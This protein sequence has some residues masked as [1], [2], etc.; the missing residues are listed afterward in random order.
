MLL[1]FNFS[2]SLE[3]CT[4]S[5]G[6]CFGRIHFRSNKHH[7]AQGIHIGNCQA[8]YHIPSECTMRAP[9][10]CSLLLGETDLINHSQT[11]KSSNIHIFRKIINLTHLEILMPD[12]SISLPWQILLVN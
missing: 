3:E 2:R 4:I 11:V 1:E 6:T 5:C 10:L 7:L 12:I 9:N 8:P